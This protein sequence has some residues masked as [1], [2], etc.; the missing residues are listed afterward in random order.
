MLLG[1]AEDVARL[2]VPVRATEAVQPV[3]STHS[4]IEHLQVTDLAYPDMCH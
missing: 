4:V 3:Q 1:A 2:D